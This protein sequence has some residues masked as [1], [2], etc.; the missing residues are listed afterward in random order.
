MH[1]VLD[2]HAV[3]GQAACISAALNVLDFSHG[4]A[5]RLG[6]YG[7][8]HALKPT[9]MAERALISWRYG[10]ITRQALGQAPAAQP[11]H[12]EA[13]EKPMNRGWLEGDGGFRGAP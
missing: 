1:D 9:S 7:R 2:P 13:E 12:K 11:P 8:G 10:L 6:G 5:G 4:G 3:D